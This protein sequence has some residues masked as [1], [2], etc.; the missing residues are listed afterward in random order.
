MF[1]YL[2]QGQIQ[3]FIEHYLAQFYSW[4]IFEDRVSNLR[5]ADLLNHA[6]EMKMSVAELISQ[7]RPL[8]STDA[9]L[10]EDCTLGIEFLERLG[11]FE[12]ARE[13]ERWCSV[14]KMDFLQLPFEAD[15]IQHVMHKIDIDGGRARGWLN[16]EALQQ[17]LRHYEE[18]ALPSMVQDVAFTRVYDDLEKSM[19]LSEPQGMGWN[20]GPQSPDESTASRPR[21]RSIF[22]PLMQPQAF[23]HPDNENPSKPPGPTETQLG[24]LRQSVRRYF[25][26]TQ[27]DVAVPGSFV[28]TL[29][30]EVR[31][32][33]PIRPAEM[34]WNA[35][36]VA[37]MN[38]RRQQRVAAAS[39]RPVQR[40]RPEVLVSSARKEIVQTLGANAAT[41]ETGA[42]RWPDGDDGH[43][44][45]LMT[46]WNKRCRPDQV[47]YVERPASPASTTVSCSFKDDIQVAGAMFSV[48]STASLQRSETPQVM[49]KTT[50]HR[51]NP[52]QASSSSQELRQFLN[53][54]Y[55]GN[56]KESSRHPKKLK[57]HNEQDIMELFDEDTDFSNVVLPE[58]E[59]D[60]AYHPKSGSRRKRINTQKGSRRKTSAD[61][62][63]EIGV[64]PKTWE[65]D[66]AEC[67]GAVQMDPSTLATPQVGVWVVF[68][69]LELT[70][71]QKPCNPETNDESN[72]KPSS[73][74][75]V[76]IVL[77]SSTITSPTRPP[78]LTTPSRPLRQ[79]PSTLPPKPSRPL[80]PPSPEIEPTSPS[81]NTDPLFGLSRHHPLPS[82]L[83]RIPRAQYAWSADEAKFASVATRARFAFTADHVIKPP[84]EDRPSKEDMSNA[85]MEM[86]RLK[87]E[88]VALEAAQKGQ[89]ARDVENADFAGC[90]DAA[91]FAQQADMAFYAIRVTGG[92]D[93]V[94]PSEKHTAK[95]G[96]GDTVMPD[97]E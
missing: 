57:S 31:Q 29:V 75:R 6:V 85:M 54:R 74:G 19:S 8:L 59:K 81:K 43:L 56:I 55:S 52:P 80:L 95:D 13:L 32:P 97:T 21:S 87:Q 5:H 73:S 79:P 11:M 94:K 69:G 16:F 39:R 4:S 22:P 18:K 24:N 27:R 89:A 20:E 82:S 66:T 62:G 48:P 50:A 71:I 37:K 61:N 67:R 46:V 12:N 58:P 15:I 2:T 7:Y 53:E 72:Q 78:P 68:D 86:Q 49:S 84:A 14:S 70:V 64:T 28:S 93:S 9:I 25:C 17:I 65:T 33:Y 63:G 51:A 40:G 26:Q 83:S 45:P 3:S 34:P 38:F 88:F 35:F 60:E 23:S 36:E 30:E 76:K 96:D 92:V 41:V 47:Q 90:A 1:L 42:G 44:N 10:R 77:K 91:F